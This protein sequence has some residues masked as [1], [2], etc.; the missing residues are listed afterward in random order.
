MSFNEFLQEKSIKD[1]RKEIVVDIDNL[2]IATTTH[3][4]ERRFR[5]R[6]GKKINEKE[7]IY[8]VE[9]ALDSIINDFA[10][11]ELKNYS[12]I[13]IKNNKTDLNVVG[14]LKMREGPDSFVVITVMRR[15]NFKP[16]A[17]TEVYEID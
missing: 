4:D 8:D 13:L 17:G 15:K 9:V 5:D 12:A 3:G 16:K 10:N 7:I 1:I 14:Q 6:F 2:E 11:G